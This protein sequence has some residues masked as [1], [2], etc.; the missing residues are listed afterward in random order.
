MAGLIDVGILKPELAGSFAAGYRGAEQARQQLAQ[1]KQ[2]TEL[3]QL[4][5][6]QLKQ[7]AIALKDLQAK[8]REVGQSDD[9]KMF[10]RAMIQTGK[11]EYMEK[12]YEG[13]RR[14][15]ELQRN[16]GLLRR[17]APDLF[18][19]AGAA[20]AA[21]PMAPVAP[22]AL[23]SG[24]FGITPAPANAL[25]PAA[26]AAPAPVNAMA[27]APAAEGAAD[28][29]AL[30][31]ELFM[32]SSI[33]DPRAKAMA[34]VIKAQINELSKPMAV[35]PGASLV[36]GGKV[37]Y[38]APERQDTDLIREYNLAKKE[39]FAGSLFDYKRMIA[40]AGRPVTPPP[41]SA[42]VAVVDPTTGNTVYVSREEALRGR[43]TPAGQGTTLAP[44]EI[45]KREATY[46]Q[47]T[48]AVKG[49]ETKSESFIKDLEALRNHPGLS[50]ITGI[51]AGR[52][53]GV[54]A[55]G[56]AA[57]ALYDKIVAKGG[58]QALQDMRDASKTGGALGN[59][60]NQEGKQLVASFAAIDRRQ[61]APDVQAAIDQAINDIRGSQARMREAYDETY[62]YRAQ[63]GAPAAAPA[64]RARQLA[65]ED[66]QA[67]D[68]ANSNP[69]DPRAAQ[70]K[71]RLG[72]Q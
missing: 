52:V 14:Y 69:K 1:E 20:P 47:A 23:G 11:P 12:G 9:P 34:D 56:R 57:Q 31:R 51:V 61:D 43:M 50:Q 68:W 17:Y 45:Q 29:N 15:D 49:F 2:Q 26:A 66:K 60:S 30:R 33:N 62:S 71:A 35:A 67:L 4:K 55:E 72:V 18:P 19:G 3:G 41:P 42:P 36:Q 64:P 28:V 46:P 8:M 24:T 32:L 63:G 37:V 21:A 7:D 53:P 40:Q 38:T 70:I 48:Q 27:P 16:E 6:E 58:F 13:L 10:F 39:G 54:T 44:K 25:A 22:G 59:V 65:P 5:L